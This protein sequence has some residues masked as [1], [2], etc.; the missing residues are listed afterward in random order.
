MSNLESCEIGRQQPLHAAALE[1]DDAVLH[2]IAM[3]RAKKN[4]RISAKA[5]PNATSAP[6]EK[7]IGL[8]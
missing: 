8:A 1:P 4:K 2:V 5:T 6:H 7:C 3:R